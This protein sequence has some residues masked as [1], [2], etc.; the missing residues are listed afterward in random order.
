MLQSLYSKLTD[1]VNGRVV[2]TN[3]DPGDHGPNAVLGSTTS[4]RASDSLE[5]LANNPKITPKLRDVGIKC[6]TW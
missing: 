5:H 4:P 1:S 6:T 2:G 3:V